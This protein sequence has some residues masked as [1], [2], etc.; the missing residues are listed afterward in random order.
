MTIQEALDRVD[1]LKPN[2][3]G[4][5][6]KIAWLSKVDGEIWQEVIMTHAPDWHL[7]HR[8]TENEDDSADP[9]E[10]SWH[11]P[12]YSMETDPN[13]EL[14]VPAP[15]DESLYTA[16][17]SAQ[18]DIVNQETDKY[19]NDATLYNAALKQFQAYWNREHMPRQRV[20]RFRWV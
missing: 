20:R 7:M 4:T 12:G 9:R 14:I 18:V 16:Y 11:F 13:T 6:T 15:Y 1:I 19:T 17:L 8:L 3:I 2:K 5:D 10:N